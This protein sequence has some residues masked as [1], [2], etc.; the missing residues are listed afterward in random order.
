MAEHPEL[1]TEK[2]PEPRY[3][4]DR[5]P[6]FGLARDVERLPQEVPPAPIPSSP[7][8]P[9]RERG[10][11]LTYLALPWSYGDGDTGEFWHRVRCRLGRHAMSGGHAMQLGGTLV[12]IE[13]RCRWCGAE[14]P[15]FRG[16]PGG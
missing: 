11:F 13:R 8:K 10:P 7:R 3:L 14:V 15:S 6:T 9:R 16:T 12:Y 5:A 4:F 2:T 1:W